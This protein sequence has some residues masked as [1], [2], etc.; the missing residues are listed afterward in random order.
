[1]PVRHGSSL[2]A[3]TQES[4][5]PAGGVTRVLQVLAFCLRKLFVQD[6]VSQVAAALTYRTIFSLIPTLVLSLI[7]FRAFI[8]LGEVSGQLQSKAF[9]YLGLSNISIPVEPHVV[10]VDDAPDAATAGASTRESE[11]VLQANADAKA[12]AQLRDNIARI[13]GQLSDKVGSLNFT[14]IGGIGMILLIWAAVALVVTVEDSFNRIYRTRAGRP[15]HLR[16][17]VYWAVITLA[18]V[19]IY[20]SIF[21]AATVEAW[22][23]N[24]GSFG[25]AL[26]RGAAPFSALLASWLLL[27]LTYTLVP[28][29]RISPRAAV[30]GSLVAAI[31][32]EA[33]KLCFHLYV[34]IAVPYSALYGTLGLIPLF[35]VWVQSTWMIVLFGLE[36]TYTLQL[37]QSGNFDQTRTEEHR[38]LNLCDP[39]AVVPVMS[40]IAAAFAR[41][42]RVEA[43]DLALSLGVPVTSLAP[44]LAG[45]EREGLITRVAGTTPA[46]GEALALA[47]PAEQIP[48]RRLLEVSRSL[49]ALHAP[50]ADSPLGKWNARLAEAQAQAADGTTLA[51]VIERPIPAA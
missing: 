46:A 36:L 1:M 50:P 27:F 18:P 41:G 34:T 35:L 21:V 47:M 23:S 9:E 38:R 43:A 6:R 10:E 33:G 5:A 17:A 44:V 7:L 15:W 19:L 14:S 13:I 8:G 26:V 25:N 39:T 37:L 11:E 24:T 40:L 16:I 30:V 49:S 12:K 45:L 31:L 4:S 3:A 28:N 32:W 48:V 42:K 51:Q 29:A 22:V 2:I 20:F